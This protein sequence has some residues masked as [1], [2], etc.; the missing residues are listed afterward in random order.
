M[1]YLEFQHYAASSALRDQFLSEVPSLLRRIV[2]TESRALRLSFH[3][4]P[5]REVYLVFVVGNSDS[6]LVELGI[7]YGL[8]RGFPILW[9][10]GRIC[11][12]F[13]FYPKFDNDERQT[14]SEFDGVTGVRFFKKWSG[15]LASVLVFQV[16]GQNLW[17]VVSKNSAESG[18]PFVADARR[19]FEP[20]LS[21]SVLSF[22]LENQLHLCAEVMSLNDQTHGARVLKECPV[23]TAAGRQPETNDKFVSFL[24]HSELVA[25]CRRLALP[26]DSAISL[27]ENDDGAA[28]SFLRELGARRDFMTDS[29]LSQLLASFSGRLTIESGTIEHR[30]ILGDCL[31]GL[32][33]FLKYGEK[34]DIVKYKFPN[35]TVR[36]MCLREAITLKKAANPDLMAATFAERWCVSPEGKKH[37]AEF[38]GRCLRA[39]LSFVPT[40]PSVGTHIQLAEACVAGEL[41]SQVSGSQVHAATVIV[42]LGP[43]GS[44]KSTFARGLV[45][46]SPNFE[47]I[48]ADDMG[49][50]ADVVMLLGKERNDFSRW[51]VVE[52]L[53]AGRAP[54]VATNGGIFF[55]NKTNKAKPKFI[56]S[57]Y[58]ATVF[59]HP[60]KIIACIAG[61]VTKVCEVG[62]DYDVASA[63]QSLDLVKSAIHYRLQ[64]SQWQLDPKFKG[65][66][67]FAEFI[68]KKSVENAKFAQEVVR[69]ADVR[70]A[71]PR[72]TGNTEYDF[73]CLVE[74]GF[75][76]CCSRAGETLNK[77]PV[78][79]FSQIR[80]LVKVSHGDEDEVGHITWQ[81]DAKRKIQYDPEQFRALGNKYPAEFPGHYHRLSPIDAK[82]FRGVYTFV[83]PDVPI[84]EDGSTHITINPGCHPPVETGKIVRAMIAGA[85]TVELMSGNKKI[86]YDL[87][88]MESKPCR[89]TNLGAFGI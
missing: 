43:I 32:V 17:T 54:V 31:E 70:V 40:V 29:G 88:S 12:C 20:Y 58:L 19:I 45:A 41:G 78:A 9:Q 60:I 16:D 68:A 64:T 2:E 10:P 15:F 46:T 69:I 21:E 4:A 14:L 61:S 50:G 3:L 53:M 84:H 89:L 37:W 72:Y 25:L 63:Y 7:K 39:A 57:D 76:G 11:R 22:L 79:N 1:K 86:I 8:P 24:S 71:F 47:L 83:T 36:T 87:V 62:A 59:Q 80:M 56:L 67:D 42:C 33:L 6:L 49:L 65:E 30:D 77:C 73:S 74:F 34:T 55:D 44:G 51:K 26:C 35:Y 82:N 23:I 27:G 66:D 81:Y 28:M 52:S 85:P 5:I 13:G 18:S 48:D 38:A 75:N